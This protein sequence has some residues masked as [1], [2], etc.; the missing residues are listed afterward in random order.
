[1]PNLVEVTYGQTGQSTK[2]SNMGMR[3]MQERA[4]SIRDAQ[5]ILLK[6]PPASG[7]SRALMFVALDKLNNQG[8]RKAIVAVPEKSIGG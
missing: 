1:V 8:I 3:E 7:K 2:T 4:Y 5:H 6:A